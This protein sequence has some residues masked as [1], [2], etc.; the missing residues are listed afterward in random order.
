MRIHQTTPGEAI[1]A[2]LIRNGYKGRQEAFCKK[3]G[4]EL[5]TFQRRKSH[6]GTMTL[7]EYWSMDQYLHFT[8]EE[9][10]VI[11]RREK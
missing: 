7:K 9:N 6:L 5:R 8:D 2:A 10:A 11:F 3:S 1:E 4:I